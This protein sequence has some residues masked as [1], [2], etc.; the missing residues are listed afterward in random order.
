MVSY[1]VALDVT[2]SSPL[3]F[4]HFSVCQLFIER[5]CLAAEGHCCQDTLEYFLVR[6]KIVP[7]C[8]VPGTNF[9]FCSVFEACGL[10]AVFEFCHFFNFFPNQLVYLYCL[11]GLSRISFHCAF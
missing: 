1:L 11:H 10:F 6:P 3:L 7:G 8:S 4:E 9:F 5:S 2:S